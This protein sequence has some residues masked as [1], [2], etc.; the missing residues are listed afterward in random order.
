MKACDK[1]EEVMCEIRM[2]VMWRLLKKENIRN[3]EIYD[4]DNV[5]IQYVK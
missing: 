5:I 4:I 2:I 1:Y 3:E